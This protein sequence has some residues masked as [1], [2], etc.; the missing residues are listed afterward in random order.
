MK[1]SKITRASG[2]SCRNRILKAAR[3]L[4]V[5]NGYAGT[6]ISQISKKAKVNHSLIFHHFTN[7][8]TLWKAVKQTYID[9]YESHTRKVIDVSG[10]LQEFI[11]GV[12]RR[13]VEL[14]ETN[15]GLQR[16]IQWQQLEPKKKADQ[17]LGGKT[18]SPD[19]WRV[20]VMELQQRGE[21][22]PDLDPALAGVMIYS[23]T[24]GVNFIRVFSAAEKRSPEQQ[25]QLR[26]NY[27]AMII[28]MLI[29]ALKAPS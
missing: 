19:A 9:D 22:N 20:A 1:T 8:D 12:V 25:Q 13:R 29:K 7:K 14:Y 6:S 2:N 23:I 28:D 17:L 16:M 26:D 5:R 10:G 11:S 4:F 21:V 3:E 24:H 15:P 27:I 18:Y